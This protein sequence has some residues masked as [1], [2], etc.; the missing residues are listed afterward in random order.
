MLER[1]HLRKIGIQ[2]TTLD[3]WMKPAPV[4]RLLCHDF[5]RG[6]LYLTVTL[7]GICVD[8]FG[9]LAGPSSGR[10]DF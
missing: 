4:I 2:P 7:T 8:A 3:C 6:L 9:G 10:H 5:I 1:V